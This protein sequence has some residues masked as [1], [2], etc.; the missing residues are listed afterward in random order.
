[1]S[2]GVCIVNK[3][4][5]ALAADSAGTLSGNNKMVY[6]S[7]NKVFSLSRKRPYGVITY[8]NS[9]ILN[10]SV[11][12]LMK[13]FRSFLDENEEL[14]DF[15][16]IVEKF[17]EFIETKFK[18]YMFE[19]FED[20][21][22]KALIKEL[23]VKW[24]NELK[25]NYIDGDVSSLENIILK[26]EELV[27]NSTRPNV[28]FDVSDYIKVKY[29]D[30]FKMELRVVF[31][32]LC[33]YDLLVERVW[34]CIS[35]YFNL[36]LKIEEE[37]FVGLLFTG[38]G[39]DDPF[40]K[41][42]HIRLSKIIGAKVKYTIVDQYKENGDNASIYPVAQSDVISTFCGGISNNLSKYIPKIMDVN[43]KNKLDKLP[44]EI[45]SQEQINY[46]KQLFMDTE[47]VIAKLINE[48]SI[49]DEIKPLLTSIQLIQLPDMAFLAESLVNITSLKRMYSLNGMQQTVGGPTDVAVISKTEGF[50]W[51]KRKHYFDKDIN[52][53]YLQKRGYD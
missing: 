5:L 12:Q 9:T 13:E 17:E 7:M 11:E 41:Y 50:I 21:P 42:I 34:K 26:Y 28:F 39:K 8:N 51:I 33:E 25:N 48:K 14:N 22:N 23:V 27:C 37:K 45:F 53:D 10:V 31:S 46:L 18:Y 36:T 38:Y 16:L 24:G 40:P 29:Y 49:N 32:K 43:V 35:N 2:V 20:A 4:G 15:F 44:K 6:N 1:M 47:I 52:P 19:E 3:N 30:Y